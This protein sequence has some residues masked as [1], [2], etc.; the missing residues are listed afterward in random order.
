MRHDLR[1]TAQRSNTQY[2][3]D[4]VHALTRGMRI[5]GITRLLAAQASDGSWGGYDDVHPERRT[6][7]TTMLAVHALIA[8]FDMD[9]FYEGSL[10]DECAADAAAAAA[11]AASFANEATVPAPSSDGSSSSSSASQQ[12]NWH[13][14]LDSLPSHETHGGSGGRVQIYDAFL[15]EDEAKEL[16]DLGME[17]LAQ[18]NQTSPEYRKAGF[19]RPKWWK[20]SETL[21]RVRERVV[22]LTGLPIGPHE[23]APM[24]A[25]SAGPR[26]KQLH[27]DRNANPK[28]YLT[29]ILYLN[30]VSGCVSCLSF[31]LIRLA[32]SLACMLV[33]Y[34]LLSNSLIGLPL[35]LSITCVCVY[36]VR[37]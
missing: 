31:S 10:P 34:P 11:A 21:R 4:C 26:V 16:R 13:T 35:S 8:T 1:S 7:H 32:C 22:R 24:Y 6:L 30:T 27:H 37:L 18:A 2:S 36:A 3:L 29:V 15:S 25:W 17:L 9:A 5:T 28:R 33:L 20:R 23:D 14:L 19:G 12:L